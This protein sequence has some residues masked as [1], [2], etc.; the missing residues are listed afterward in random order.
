MYVLFINHPL[1]QNSITITL[2][3]LKGFHVA[4]A[5]FEL[6]LVQDHRSR[7]EHSIIPALVEVMTFCLMLTKLYVHALAL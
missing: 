1:V 4:Y 3:C 2:M 7:C 5:T 6:Y